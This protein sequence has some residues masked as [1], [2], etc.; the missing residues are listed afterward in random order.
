MARTADPTVS[1][2]QPTSSISPYTQ[3]L[4]GVNQPMNMLFKDV[5]WWT[6][7][8]LAIVVLLIRLAEI[9]W[10]K[11][12]QV[13]AMSM[14][15]EK[16]NYWRISQWTWMPA[17]KKH[18]TYAP[19]WR[20]RHNREIRLSTAINVG[21]LPSRLHL[22]IIM[23]HAISN[24][25]YMFYLRWNVANKYALCA[26]LRGRSG[27]LA[28]VN[29]V[30]LIILAGRNNPLIPLLKISFDTYNLLHRWLGRI[31]VA[32]IIIHTIAWLVP[33]V[34]DGGWASAKGAMFH[35]IF[36][37]SGMI[38]LVAMLLILILSLSPLRHA[39]YETFVN[40]HIILALITFVGTW[41]HC[42]SATIPGGLPQLPWIMIVM[43]IWLVE[44]LVRFVRLVYI[45]WSDRGFT[46][47]IC[48]ALPGN[49]T[50]VT[51]RLP[52]FVDV[53]PGTHAYLRFIGVSSWESHPFS[54]A[55]VQHNHNSSSLPIDEKD[56]F[57]IID[58]SKYTT[59]VS[60]I[61][62]AHTGMTRKLFDK[63][64][65]SGRS[66]CLRAAMEGPY[67]GHH[68]LDSYGHAVLFAGSTGI[69]HQLSYIRH[70]LEGYNNGTVATRRLTLIWVVREYEA[71]EW[72]RPYMDALLR[73]PHRKDILRINV[74]VTRP[75]NPQDIVSSSTTVKMFPGRPNVGLLIAKEAQEQ[76][77]AMCV[78]VCG[79]GALADDVRD[80]VRTS[81]GQTVID[82]VEESFTW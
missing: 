44:R 61:V 56:D 6:L 25:V 33:K 77:G 5:M 59:Q 40:I 24:V 16:Q 64:E 26:E 20:K 14:P 27:T 76:V 30:P 55:W 32:E 68:S 78:T 42:G 46:D 65:R 74:F 48:E 67:A 7:G 57:P 19:L 4:E 17:L 12:R 28:L 72:V 53:Q 80:A 10:A 29:M 79:P 2:P 71:L 75:K 22:I 73:I 15:R 47:A 8:I 41:V 3:A 18:L 13:S 63:V 39:F 66:L 23:L 60:F 69:T 51:L 9:A 52:R 31:C 37:G 70:L 81:Q 45:N 35:S 62:G 82:F 34:A 54:I 21:T 1:S 58:R 11:L 43:G 50:R 38:G 49:V 36:I